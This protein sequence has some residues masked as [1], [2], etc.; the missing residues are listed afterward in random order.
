MKRVRKGML[1]IVLMIAV[2]MGMR[3]LAIA[4]ETMLPSDAFEHASEHA[5]EEY[6]TKTQNAAATIIAV[7]QV[8]GVTVATAML[9]ILAIK[10]MSMA[11]E[12]KADIKKSMTMYIVGALILFGATGLLQIFKNAVES[13]DGSS[14]GGTSYP[15]EGIPVDDTW[16]HFV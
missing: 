2:L 10:Y 3:N 12:G 11:P 16:E 5:G 15:N 4:A 9:L 6:V 7:V 13:L 14:S 1:I 8:V